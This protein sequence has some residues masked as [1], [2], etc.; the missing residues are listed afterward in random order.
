MWRKSYFTTVAVMLMFTVLLTACGGNNGDE[1]NEGSSSGEGNNNGGDTTEKENV[2]LGKKDITLLGDNYV[3]VTA[4]MYVAKQVLEDVG[5]NVDIKEVGVGTMFAGIADGSADV[6]MAIW[7]PHTHADYW[8][9]YKDQIDKFGNVMDKVPLGLTVPSYM[10][11]INSIEDLADNKNNIGDKLDWT[12][13]G[14]DPGAGEMQVTK[15]DVMPAYGLKDKWEL[16]ASSGP[17][18]SGALKKAIAKKEPI[19]VTLWYPH[20]AFVK[21]DL[22]LLKDPKNKYGDPDKVYIGARKGFK[23][24]SPA[25][26]KILKQFHWKVEQNESVMLDFQKGMDHDK[27]AQKFIKNHPDLK[28]E[29]MKGVNVKDQ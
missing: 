16:Q 12:I 3:S 4:S 8:E 21:W 9:Q 15:N 11:D 14:I 24:D 7:L 1:N 29:W 5:Y 23:E 22:K 28:K 19:V 20:W 6:S 27:A 25:A 18:M 10:K 2:G 26:A 13:T 17:A